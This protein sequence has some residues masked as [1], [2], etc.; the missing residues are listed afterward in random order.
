MAYQRGSPTIFVIDQAFLVPNPFDADPSDPIVVINSDLAA[1]SR[2]GFGALRS[3]L[4]LTSI[5]SEGTVRLQTRGLDLALDDRDG[6]EASVRDSAVR[7][8]PHQQRSWIDQV[9][10]MVALAAPPPVLRDWALALSELGSW[11]GRGSDEAQID[12][13][14]NDGEVQVLEDFDGCLARAVATRERLFPGHASER[15]TADE[16]E[17]VW[18]DP[19]RARSVD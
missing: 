4:P 6:Y 11:M 16:R 2:E 1:P 19:T 12:W 8:N 10:G 18:A 15:L 3:R 14:R 9:K 13:P 17:R 7:W 5:R